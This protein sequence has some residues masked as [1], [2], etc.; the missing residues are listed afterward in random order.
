MKWVKDWSPTLIEDLDRLVALEK[1]RGAVS[2]SW[3]WGDGDRID[4]W[5]IKD[6]LKLRCVTTG[7]I[8]NLCGI[9]RTFVYLMQQE[10]GLPE[11]LAPRGL[12]DSYGLDLMFITVQQLHRGLDPSDDLLAMLPYCGDIA[13]V[14]YLTGVP[15]SVINRYRLRKEE[16]DGSDHRQRMAYV[17]N[18]HDSARS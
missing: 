10:Y 16:F 3:H 12:L 13:I 15:K 14:S 18:V 8:A 4:R 9:S 11:S 6:L 5:I 2:R 1:L 17:A 7:Q